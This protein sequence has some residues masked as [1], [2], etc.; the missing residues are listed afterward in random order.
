MKILHLISG[1]D[2]GGAKTHVFTLLQSLMESVDVMV[3]CFMEGVFY[4]E[5]SKTSIPHMLIKQRF[6]NDL[7]IISRLVKLIRKERYNLIHT[8]GARANFIAMFLKPFIS[9]PI[10]TTM[11]SDYRMD[12]TENLYKKMLFT[13]LNAFSLKFMDYFIAVSDNFKDMLVQRGF[14]K[15]DIYTVYNAVNFEK[16]LHFRSKEVFLKDMGLKPEGRTLVGIIGRFDKVKGHEVFIRACAKAL[17]T[18]K[19]LLFLLAGDGIEQSNLE[20]LCAELNI[21]DSVVFLGFVSDI[22]SFINA[23]DVNVCSS[24]SESFPYML[25]EGAMLKK[26]TVSTAVGGIPD[27]ILHEKTGLLVESGDYEGMAVAI[28]RLAQDDALRKRLGE[29]LYEYSK[30][31]FSTENMKKTHVDIYKS[32]LKRQKEKGKLYD[33]MLAGYYGFNNS[34]DEALVAAIIDSLKKEDKELSILLVS[35]NPKQASEKYGVSSISRSN[36]FKIRKSMKASRVFIYGGGSI[37]QDITSTQSLMYYSLLLFFAKRLGLKVMLYANG[38]GPIV[39]KWN[40]P[41]AKWALQVCDVITLREKESFKEIEKLGV[42][43]DDVIQSCDPT[44]SLVPADYKRIMEVCKKEG[45]DPTKKYLA[46]SFRYWKNSEMDTAFASKMAEVIDNA[47][48]KHNLHALFIPMQ[49]PD[50]ALFC[51]EIMSKLT[52][53]CV[54]IKSELK[55]QELMG[56]IAL[57]ELVVAMRLHTL[58]YAFSVDKPVIGLVYDPKIKAF[59]EYINQPTYFN[60]DNLDKNAVSETI[61]DIIKRLPQITEGIREKSQMLKQISNKDAGI[62]LKLL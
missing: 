6:R 12:F 3:I 1:G 21:S 16:Q 62:A 44:L 14:E 24:Y 36:F 43:R 15:D 19:S 56:V 50:D 18:N 7:T 30:G 31:N 35:K 60:I 47:C 13:G 42:T 38:I 45:I 23:I 25:L 58:I 51:K 54:I 2:K 53:P 28:N 32:V 61:D 39:R 17:E 52:V 29:N 33:I 37:I 26:A 4:K 20:R 41:T 49:Y 27:L 22:F 9:Q 48:K 57:A 40:I 34:G 10:I 11:H 55:V 46:L 59:M 8:H 5:L